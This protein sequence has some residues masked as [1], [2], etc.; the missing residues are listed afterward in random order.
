MSA[1][2]ICEKPRITASVILTAKVIAVRV[3]PEASDH[4]VCDCDV[5]VQQVFRC[6]ES[7]PAVATF[8]YHSYEGAKPWICGIHQFRRLTVGE[9]VLIFAASF[10]GWLSEA[11]TIDGKFIEVLHWLTAT[12][13]N[14]D[15][16]QLQAMGVTEAE[17]QRLGEVYAA[18]AKAF[19]TV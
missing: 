14:L 8:R 4:L 6:P 7:V 16:M 15:T 3:V 1:A 17:R 13:R 9:E 10:N 18:I 5:E 19:E 2:F 11:F 12:A